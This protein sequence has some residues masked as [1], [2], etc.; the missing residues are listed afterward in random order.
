MLY[1]R[2][3]E[4]AES[5]LATALFGVVVLVGLGEPSACSEGAGVF[6][7]FAG[8]RG[9]LVDFFAVVLELPRFL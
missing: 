6:D 1:Q 5:S 8:A 7:A 4:E 9:T 3:E 2:R